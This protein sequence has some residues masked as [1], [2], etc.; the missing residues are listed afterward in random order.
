MSAT[1]AAP[2]S[3]DPIP[4]IERVL[5]EGRPLLST[6]ESLIALD[7]P[8]LLAARSE[9]A[10]LDLAVRRVTAFAFVLSSVVGLLVLSRVAPTPLA[11]I[12]TVWLVASIG[13]RLFLRRRRRQ[14]GRFLLDFDRG[15]VFGEALDGASID[16]P[17]GGFR[18]RTVRSGDEESPIWILLVSP[19]HVIRLGR[20][21]E[22][23][24]DRVLA[25]LRGQRLSVDR[26]HDAGGA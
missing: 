6:R 9:G 17:L 15:R 8:F 16:A 7:A 11:A 12:V 19:E 26:A 13:A 10:T 1:G 22:E 18:V 2:T 14:H 5:A 4:C 23:A 24:V 25:T 20:G 3:A 21:P